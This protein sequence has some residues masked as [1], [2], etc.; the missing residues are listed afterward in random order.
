MAL[1][2]WYF[3]YA[4]VRYASPGVIL[5]HEKWN[6]RNIMQRLSSIAISHLT[7]EQQSGC[8]IFIW[9]TNY[10]FMTN[11][12]FFNFYFYHYFIL[13]FFGIRQTTSPRWI[14]L[15]RCE[16]GSDACLK[17]SHPWSVTHDM[18]SLFWRNACMPCGWQ[19]QTLQISLHKVNYAID[20]ISQS[21]INVNLFIMLA[22]KNKRIRR[23]ISRVSS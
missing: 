13:F 4:T 20:W 11:Y 9:I 14:F 7:Q 17:Y 21:V 3:R 1:L 23:T 12:Y 15:V 2:Y 8:E 6:A 22:I 18:P 16:N 19:S 5:V 10:Y